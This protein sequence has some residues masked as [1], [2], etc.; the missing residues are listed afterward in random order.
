LIDD[1][2]FRDFT[3]SNMVQLHGGVNPDFFKGT[4]VEDAATK[5]LKR[6]ARG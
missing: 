1:E 5:E 4:T 6:K 3:F 2:D